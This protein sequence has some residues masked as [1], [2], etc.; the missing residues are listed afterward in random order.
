MNGQQALAVGAALALTAIVVIAA[1]QADYTNLPPSCSA[2]EKKIRE[3]WVTL[4]EAI[5]TAQHH[6]AGVARSASFQFDH[7]PA[8]IEVIVFADGAAH[9]V[10]VGVESGEVLES[11]FMPWVPGVAI[12]DDWVEYSSGVKIYDIVKG[13]EPAFA[14]ETS[15]ARVQFAIYLTDG[16]KVEDT[17]AQNRPVTWSIR[18]VL[19]SMEEAIANLGYG[20]RRVMLIPAELAFGARGNPRQGIPPNATLI[21]DVEVLPYVDFQAVPATEDLPGDPVEGEPVT[22]DTGLM[23]YDIVE[24][25]GATPAGPQS[26]VKVHYTGW[27]VDGTKFDSSYD[28]GQPAQFRLDRVIAGWT[29]GLASMRVGGKR[30]LIIPYQLG[31][32]ERGSGTIPPNATLVFDVELIDVI[33]ADGDQ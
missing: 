11:T 19:P 5:E 14:D 6:L 1:P 20:G 3:S 25:D 22:T 28:R 30:K 12:G 13:G 7:D 2:V 9:R 21:F 24:G 17:R 8:A 31:Y 4:P 27:L 15:S 26:T 23:Y 16:T 32:G 29:E 33:G 18:R 10:L